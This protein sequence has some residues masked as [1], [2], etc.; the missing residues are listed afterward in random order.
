MV[1]ALG[2]AAVPIYDNA[3]FWDILWIS[4]KGQLLG[5]IKTA[6][7]GNPIV[8]GLLNVSYSSVY[9]YDYDGDADTNGAPYQYVKYTLKGKS[10]S[11]TP[12]FT[13]QDMTSG[14]YDPLPN[15]GIIGISETNSSGT[16][17]AFSY[18]KY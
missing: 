18:Y 8:P 12:F 17:T 10:I 7:T 4:A 1:D 16:P 9:T 11:R 5:V 3:G 14:T 2:N 15:S 13:G 6:Y